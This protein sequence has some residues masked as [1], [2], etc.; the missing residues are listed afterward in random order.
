MKTLFHGP[1]VFRF[2]REIEECVSAT[3]DE[4]HC[5]LTYYSEQNHLS[6]RL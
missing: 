3:D 6:S 1:G 2:D 5:C 4:L